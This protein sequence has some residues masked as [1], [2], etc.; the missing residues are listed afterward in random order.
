MLYPPML[1]VSNGLLVHDAYDMI[2]ECDTHMIGVNDTVM[3]GRRM[4]SLLGNTQE[5]FAG[6][7][8]RQFICRV[9]LAPLDEFPAGVS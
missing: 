8:S 6:S 4:V 1:D 2:C 9:P 5:P 3:H 7:H